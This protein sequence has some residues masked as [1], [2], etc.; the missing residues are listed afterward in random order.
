MCLYGPNKKDEG[1]VFFESLYQAIDQDLAVFLYGD[2]NT[3]VNPH[4]DR[5]SCN[6]ESYWAYNQ[7]LTLSDQMAAF[8]LC[9]AWHTKHPGDTEFMC[10]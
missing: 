10:C 2:F 5:F 9:D 7:S 1:A 6:P 3:M 8:E 4:L